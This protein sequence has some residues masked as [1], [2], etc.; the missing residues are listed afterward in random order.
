MA[1]GW[2]LV[3]GEWLLCSASCGAHARELLWPAHGFGPSGPRLGQGGFL[4]SGDRSQLRTDPRGRVGE[5]HGRPALHRRYHRLTGNAA[6]PGPV[7]GNPAPSGR[8]AAD[9]G[10]RSLEAGGR[11]QDGRIDYLFDSCNGTGIH[12]DS[13]G[14]RLSPAHRR[15]A[16]RAGDPRKHD[17]AAG[18]IAQSGWRG[19]CDALVSP[20][21]RHA[22]RRRQPAGALPEVCGARQQ[23]RLVHVHAKGNA[24][25]HRQAAQ[26]L[27][28]ADRLRRPPDGFQCGA[29]L[30]ATVAGPH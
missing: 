9:F 25:G 22:V 2:W 19:H 17:L 1:G 12:P 16:P 7:S 27:A 6:S 13:R 11:R 3:A 30:R 21:P 15:H 23:S 18:A 5:E 28:S 20:N 10:R 24:T 8:S 14:V 26:R 4:F 29:H